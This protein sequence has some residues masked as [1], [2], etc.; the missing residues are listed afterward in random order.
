MKVLKNR[1]KFGIGVL[2]H[3]KCIQCASYKTHNQ[4]KTTHHLMYTL[5]QLAYNTI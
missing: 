4:K 1:L 5:P 3:I 2:Y